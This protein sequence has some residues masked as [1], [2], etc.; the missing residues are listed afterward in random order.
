TDP[1]ETARQLVPFARLENKPLL[2]SWMGGEEVR[3]GKAV[4]N[5]ANI[6]TFDSPEAAI[7]AFLHM[8]QY[9]RSPE[10]LSQTP[11]ALPEDWAPDQQKVRSLVAAARA[12][13]RTL[14]TEVEAK[15][16]L[17]AYGIPVTPTARAATAEEAVAA[18][19]RVGYPVVL[20]L[21]S[22]TVT[23]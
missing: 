11:A 9:R 2:A 1:T 18:A 23:H 12:A 22:Q 8:V 13:G 19:A 10:L 16:L 6:P 14:L 21:F 15:E 3:P 5:Q 17:A 20:K 4:H 7:R